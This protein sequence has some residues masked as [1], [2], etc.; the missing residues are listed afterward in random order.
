MKLARH[1]QLDALIGEYILGSL[2]GG[3]RRRFERALREEPAVW[4][5]LRTLQQEFTPNY[6]ER[7]A[8]APPAVT[9]MTG[10]RFRRAAVRKSRAETGARLTLSSPTGG[11]GL[12]RALSSDR[13]SAVIRPPSQ[14]IAARSSALRSSRTFPGQS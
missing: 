9:P 8:Q 3:A 14:R 2:R 11:S 6:S 10:M 12:L 13:C 5:R 7:I 1:R 4:L